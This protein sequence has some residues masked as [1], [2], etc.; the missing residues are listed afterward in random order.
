[1]SG[2]VSKDPEH[3][4]VVASWAYRYMAH[5]VLKHLDPGDAVAR[6]LAHAE[7][8]GLLYLDLEKVSPRELERFRRALAAAYVD[9]A[10]AGPSSL[11][12]GPEFFAGFMDRL[13]ELLELFEVPVPS[14]ASTPGNDT[15]PLR[16]S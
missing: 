5:L 13:R 3:A 15:E 12:W 7:G 2:V 10:K 8:P 11:R 14:D 9:A 4:W 16:L 1:M 6:E